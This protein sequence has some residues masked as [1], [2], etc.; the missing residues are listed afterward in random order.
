VTLLLLVRHALTEATGRRLSGNAPGHHLSA[1][2]RS[3]AEALAERLRPLRLA[4]VYSSPIERCVETAEAVAAPRGVPVH[5]ERDLREVE[6]G[7]WTGRPLAQL[8]RTALWKRLQQHPSGVRFPD[9]ESLDEVQTRAARALDAIAARHP[10][11]IVAAVT[12]ADV[13]RLALAHYSGIHLDLYQRLI[14][15]PASVTAIALGDRIPRIV[16]TNDTGSLD[17]LGVRARRPVASA[18]TG[19]RT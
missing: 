1:A 18:P 11:G 16:R 15:S 12:H 7:R 19:R 5:G 13:I 17:D 6:Y 4:A 3:Q 8:A 10:R 9:G 14:V 2:G